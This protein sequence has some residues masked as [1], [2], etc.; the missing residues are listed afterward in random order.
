MPRLWPV[1]TN[2]EQLFC[3]CGGIVD[4]GTSTQS[5]V[6]KPKPV[7]YINMPGSR[8]RKL[9]SGNYNQRHPGYDL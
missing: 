7:P 1:E 3:T 9:A 8:L 4:R 6:G 2:P 5:D